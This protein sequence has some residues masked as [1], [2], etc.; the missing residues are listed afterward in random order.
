[1]SKLRHL[2]WD[3]SQKIGAWTNHYHHPAY[4]H[5]TVSL[6]YDVGA[7]VLKVEFASQPEPTPAKK[8]RA[9]RPKAYA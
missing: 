3:D 7:N 1:M 4:G 2:L 6:D 8:K 5:V 9:A